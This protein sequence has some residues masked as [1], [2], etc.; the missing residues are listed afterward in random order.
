MFYPSPLTVDLRQVAK[1]AFTEQQEAAS[2]EPEQIDFDMNLDVNH[3]LAQPAECVP[4]ASFLVMLI[5][6]II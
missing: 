3:V 1:A 4:N 6:S 2:I 5:A